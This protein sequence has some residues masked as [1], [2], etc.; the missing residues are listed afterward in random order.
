MNRAALRAQFRSDA[1]DSA[2][3]YLFA[4]TDV[5]AWLL[6]AV[7]EAAVRADLLPEFDSAPVCQLAVV[8]GTQGYT[9]HT[10]ISRVTRA[11]FYLGTESANRY[12]LALIDR[13]ELDRVRP[14]WRTEEG[15]PEVLL[16]EKGKARL[17]PKPTSAGV[18]LLEVFRRPLTPMAQDSDSPEIPALHHRYL[19]DWAL[20]RA[21]S[22]PDTE[23]YDAGRA[24]AALA[25]FEDRFGPAPD[26]DER[27]A[28][29][30]VPHVNKAFW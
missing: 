26:A 30:I 16:I 27:Q 17:V 19:V 23:T 11:D 6:E 20:Y 28:D 12:E 29:E 7:E 10:A 8:A 5:N 15:D 2:T 14:D 13:I 9:L 21:Y 18:V 4:D 22:R 1:D 25:R 3:P 24:D